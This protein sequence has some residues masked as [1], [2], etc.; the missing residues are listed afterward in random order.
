MIGHQSHQISTHLTV[1]CSGVACNVSGIS[2]TAPNA[3]VPYTSPEQKIVLQ[4]IWD[5]LSLPQTAQ[6]LTSFTDA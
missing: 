3:E 4:Q 6:L 1:R 5:D 2:Q